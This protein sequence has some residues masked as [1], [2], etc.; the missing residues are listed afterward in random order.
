MA[1]NRI[2]GRVKEEL[3]NPEVVA[4][5]KRGRKPFSITKLPSDWRQLM[6][7]EARAGGGVTAFQVRLGIGTGAFTSLLNNYPEFREH[8]EW[9]LLLSQHWWETLGRELATGERPKGNAAIWSLNMTNRF[10]WRTLRNELVGD[11]DNPLQ[12]ARADSEL[13]KED[14]I[15]ELKR[16]GLPTTIFDR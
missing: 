2:R 15:E 9:C 3:A 1:S 12:I 6:E 7:E 10:G 16:R 5:R 4:L 13:T 14:L 8:Y 11:K